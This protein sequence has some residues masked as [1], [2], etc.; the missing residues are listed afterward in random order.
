M[1]L[2]VHYRC[3]YC[4]I[5]LSQFSF[6]QVVN[7]MSR[8]TNNYNKIIIISHFL[9]YMKYSCNLLKTAHTYI[10]KIEIKI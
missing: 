10:F 2:L 7:L 8:F 4:I 5:P 3:I 9:W 1:C 6:V